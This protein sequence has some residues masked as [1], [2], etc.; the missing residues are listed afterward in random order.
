MCSPNLIFL[1]YFTDIISNLRKWNKSTYSV[2]EKTLIIEF[3]YLIDKFTISTESI[4]HSNVKNPSST[5]MIKI[6]C[7]R[8]EFVAQGKTTHKAFIS[9][10]FTQRQQ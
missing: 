1:Y 10:V 3:Y 2:K 5:N 6:L 4:T 7:T 9:K 8:L